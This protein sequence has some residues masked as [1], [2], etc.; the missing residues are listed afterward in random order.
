[1]D[2]LRD[3]NAPTGQFWDTYT[4][5]PGNSGADLNGLFRRKRMVGS[6]VREEDALKE[7][8]LQQNRKSL[9]RMF[10]RQGINEPGQ[11]E[12]ILNWILR[13][14]NNGM[15]PQRGPRGTNG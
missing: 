5:T 3:P 13:M 14:M 8:S 12:W 15:N 9:Q 1:M 7:L 6:Y 2:W 10:E 4:D 11:R